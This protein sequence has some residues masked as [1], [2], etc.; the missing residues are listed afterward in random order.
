MC[1][2][3]YIRFFALHGRGGITEGCRLPGALKSSLLVVV[4]VV[5]YSPLQCPLRRSTAGKARRVCSRQTWVYDFSTY[6][7]PWSLHHSRRGHQQQE[8]HC[9]SVFTGPSSGWG[10][11]FVLAN[12]ALTTFAAA[13]AGTTIP[14]ST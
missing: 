14:G 2:R 1:G 5:S 3:A 9:G 10:S 12:G 4:A 11:G 6:V 8:R 7:V 13:G